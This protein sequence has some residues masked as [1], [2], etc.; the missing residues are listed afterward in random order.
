MV[1]NYKP[2]AV[3]ASRSCILQTN[4]ER[5][6]SNQDRASSRSI[7][8]GCCCPSFRRLPNRLLR[9]VF[10]TYLVRNRAICSH[11]PSGVCNFAENT[12]FS[13]VETSKK[14]GQPGFCDLH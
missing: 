4:T 13:D 9:Q 1:F 6:V 2:A 14:H 5:K 8:V 11:L 7:R 3:Y 10:C 12:D